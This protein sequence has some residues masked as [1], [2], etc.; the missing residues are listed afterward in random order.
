MPSTRVPARSSSVGK[1]E[2]LSPL[3]SDAGCIPLDVAA[4]ERGATGT[5]PEPGSAWSASVG[6]GAWGEAAAACAIRA[7]ADA[8]TAGPP[9]T[10]LDPLAEERP[11]S[12]LDP[13]PDRPSPRETLRAADRCSILAGRLRGDPTWNPA[14]PGRVGSRSPTTRVG[15]AAA[16]PGAAS[17]LVAVCDGTNMLA[18]PPL[19]D[20]AAS[21]TGVAATAAFAARYE[22]RGSTVIANRPTRIGADGP[23]RL[24]DPRWRVEVAF[25]CSAV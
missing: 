16:T 24:A 15:T 23:A 4:A 9:L 1:R 3:G 21:T 14:E 7:G 6:R 17:D 13:G 11:A 22:P 18:N 8:R 20:T 5:R 12:P 2:T 25:P 10:L 19:T